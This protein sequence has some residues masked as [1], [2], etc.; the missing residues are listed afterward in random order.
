MALRIGPRLAAF[1]GE[2]MPA[3]IGTKRS[4]GS[5]QINPV[6]FDYK[7]GT[8][9]LNGGENRGWLKHA[10]KDRDRITIFFI[11]PKNMWR[12]AQLQGRIVRTTTEGAGDHINDLSRRYLGRDYGRSTADRLLIE[13]VPERVTGAGGGQPWD[14]ASD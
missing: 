8:I 13:V 9:R 1:L 6:W 10:R 5:V 3:A 7:E 4:D 11:D 2:V 12:Y 14:V